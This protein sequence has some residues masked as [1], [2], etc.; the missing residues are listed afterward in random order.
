MRLGKIHTHENREDLQRIYKMRREY[1]KF[2]KKISNLY[3]TA[4]KN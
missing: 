3:A 2:H 1:I 4:L